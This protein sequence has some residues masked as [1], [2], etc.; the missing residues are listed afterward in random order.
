MEKDHGTTIPVLSDLCKSLSDA[1][2]AAPLNINDT[3]VIVEPE[4][5]VDLINN[6][7]VVNRETEDVPVQVNQN[8]ILISSDRETEEVVS[9]QKLKNNGKGKQEC[10]TSRSR[11]KKG[12][13]QFEKIYSLRPRKDGR[14]INPAGSTPETAISVEEEKKVE[15]RNN[16]VWFSLVAS[17]T[18]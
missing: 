6:N 10:G 7:C 12:K 1:K 17:R 11:K 16:P 2:E 14:T 5:G 13:K 18:Q 4:E 9:G 8:T 15:G 3:P